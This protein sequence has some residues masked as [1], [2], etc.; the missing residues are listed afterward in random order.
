MANTVCS[1]GWQN[2]PLAVPQQTGCNRY[3][4]MKKADEKRRTLHLPAD[5]IAAN[6]ANGCQHFPRTQHQ[7]SRWL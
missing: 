5:S 3:G 1:A 2:S 4:L 7:P 6:I